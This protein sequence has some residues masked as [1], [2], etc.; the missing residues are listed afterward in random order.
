M[1]RTHLITVSLTAAVAIP[2]IAAGQDRAMT[3]RPESRVV[4]EGSSNVVDWACR[5]NAFEATI[6]VDSG[7][8]PASLIGLAKPISRVTVRIP[9]RTLKCGH[10]RMNRDMYRSLRA[11]QF[12]DIR[13]VLA[14]YTVKGRAADSSKF[15][16]L[17]VGD[18]TVA[19]VTKRV[20]V[21]IT[22][23]RWQ[24]GA[25]GSGVVRLR[26]TDFGVRPPVALLGAI[27]TRNEVEV[28]FEVV[29]DRAVV[30]ALTRVTPRGPRP[31]SA[32]F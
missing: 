5:T 25:K 8:D 15:T 24:G 20:E 3:V 2:S 19:G 7:F 29:L 6:A 12:P 30:V 26:M 16:L 14:S 22:A 23:E 27:R 28:L 11:S 17:T 1:I 4:L 13:Y 10:D 9:V 31:T 18:I 21:P 32:R